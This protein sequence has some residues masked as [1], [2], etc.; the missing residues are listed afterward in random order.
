MKLSY[1]KY[2]GDF[3]RPSDFFHSYYTKMKFAFL[4]TIALLLPALFFAQK[5]SIPIGAIVYLQKI[6]LQGEAQ[7]NGYSTLL[8]NRSTSIYIQNSAPQKDSSFSTNEY[9]SFTLAGDKEG[10]PIYKLHDEHQLFCKIPCRQSMKHCIVRDT[11]GN[12]VWVLQPEHKRFNQYDCRRATCKFRGRE[13]EVWYTL[14]IPIPSGPFKLGGLPGLILEARSL[15]GIVEF[16]FSSLKLS[17]LITGV[18]Q[19]PTGKDIG[20]TNA[21][22]IKDRENFR[23]SVIKDAKARGQEIIITFMEAIEL[24]MNN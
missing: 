12:I 6:D 2:W 23:L 11:F 24:D 15:D 3:Y 21:E 9:Y 20:M 1:C 22:Y 8:F 13:Y 7:N 16:T 18:I 10:F 4:L 14:D 19:P 17:N 5:D